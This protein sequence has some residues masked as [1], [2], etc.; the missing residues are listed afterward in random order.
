[1]FILGTLV[2][3]TNSEEIKLGDVHYIPL[4]LHKTYEVSAGL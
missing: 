4:T 3:E 1:M 2:L